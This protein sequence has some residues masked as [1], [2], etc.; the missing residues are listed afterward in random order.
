MPLNEE[1]P[2]MGVR[3]P[4]P[5]ARVEW[6]EYLAALSARLL[7]HNCCGTFYLTLLASSLAE[8][9]WIVHPYAHGHLRCCKFAYPSSPW[10]FAIETYLTAGLLGE[11]LLRW[12][13]QRNTFWK[14]GGNLFDAAGCALSVFSFLLYEL[15]EH[16]ELV[17]VLVLL[18]MIVMLAVRMVRFVTIAKTVHRQRSRSTAALTIDIDLDLEE[19]GAEE[20]IKEEL[21]PDRALLGGSLGVSFK[22]TP[23]VKSKRIPNYVAQADDDEVASQRLCAGPRDTPGAPLGKQWVRV[24]ATDSW[25]EE[26]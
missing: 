17:D 19:G 10:F 4:K 23:P 24:S 25:V 13:R 2:L 7:D 22:A 11:T 5:T 20:A 26:R 21:S 18:V 16:G 12:L 15:V 3:A 8:I 14:Q 9:V 6:A 1:L